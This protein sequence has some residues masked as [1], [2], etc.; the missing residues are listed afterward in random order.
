MKRLTYQNF[1]NKNQDRIFS[2]AMYMLR[3]RE[4]AEDVT[5]EVF[6]KMWKNWENIHKEKRD[7]WILKVAHNYCIDMLRKK[8]SPKKSWSTIEDK[9]TD[10]L[11]I[12]KSITPEKQMEM[13][14][15][16]K[17]LLAAMSNMPE[18]MRSMML[19][20]YFQGEKFEVI[21]DM[22]DMSLSAVKTGM[23]RGRKQLKTTMERQYPEL[24]GVSNVQAA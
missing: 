16:Q 7:A 21:A 4:D 24:A 6:V 20:H 2:Y 3:N 8:H 1:L 18:K 5:Q 22:L 10:S 13:T 14:E 19:L 17:A 23:H 9:H 12:E 11:S 15:V